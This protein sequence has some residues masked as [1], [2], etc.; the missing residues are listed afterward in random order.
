MLDELIV[1]FSLDC[2][3]RIKITIIVTWV[4]SNMVFLSFGFSKNV[5]PNTLMDS[6]DPKDGK[7][8]ANG[9]RRGAEVGLRAL[10]F[11]LEGP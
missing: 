7:R 4:C 9:S 2:E 1:T 6:Q 3:M 8:R 5:W 10:R 11:D